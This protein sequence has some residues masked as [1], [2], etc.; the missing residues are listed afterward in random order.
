LSNFAFLR[1]EWP[2]LFEEAAK[3]ESRV[4]ADPTEA[5]F[6]ARRTLE[7]IVRWLF[8]HDSSL[9]W[10]YGQPTLNDLLHDAGF[11][12]LASPKVFQKARLIKDLGNRAVH[13]LRGVAPRDGAQ[14][15]VE[16]FHVCFW[17][18][19]T[20]AR[21]GKP[22]AGMMFATNLVPDADGGLAKTQAQLRQL[23]E[24][25]A[26]R[27]SALAEER[28]R[29]A[30]LDS[31]IAAVRAEIAAAK[32]ANA[33]VADTHDYS[34][35]QTRDYFIDVLLREAGWTLTRGGKDTEYEVTGMPNN[36]GT[37]YA[38]YVLW[39]RNDKPLAV[40]EA[41]RTMRDAKEGQ[42][43]AK[44]YA[45]CLEAMH[46]QRPVIFF[47]NGYEHFIWDDALY[48]PRAVQGFYTRA[49]LELAIQRR[50]TRASLADTSIDK[51][52]VDRY[53]Q[54]RA[55][56]KMGESFERD[57]LRK[58]L[59][60]MATGSGKTRTVIA[61][62]DVLMRA[63][64]V[65]NVLFLADR[66]ALVRQAVNAFKKHLPASSPINLV[67]DKKTDGRVYVST[68]PSM[69][70]QLE[71]QEGRVRFGPGFFD[72]VVIDEAHRSV[73][74]RYR[75]IFDY[76]D[77][78]LIGLTATP[79]A[80]IDRN[81]YSLFDLPNDEPTDVYELA[82][83]VADRNLVPPAPKAIDLQFPRRGIRYADLSEDE[84]SEWEEKDWDEDGFIP[85]EVDPEAVNSWLFNKDTV[86]KM[87]EQLMREGY[88]VAGGDRLGKTIIFAKNQR[89][90][91]FI[92][93]RFNI[94]YPYF[95]GR[96]ARVIHN[97]V[98]YAQSLIDEFS[99]KEKE[100]HIAV[101]VDML[102][103][104]IDVPEVLNLVFAKPV[105]SPTK[106]WQ[107]VGRGTRL[108]PDVFDD[109][110]HKTDFKIFDYCGN[111]EF[112][113]INPTAP[114]RSSSAS[115]GE[116]LFV[117]RLELITTL[118]RKGKLQSDEEQA[119]RHE[120]AAHLHSVVQGMTLDNFLIRPHRLLVERYTDLTAWND[121]AIFNA[122]D[123]VDTLAG[124]PSIVSDN[125][126]DAKQFDLLMFRAQLALLR[127]ET[128]F[129][130]LRGKIIELA[131][132]LQEKSTI[133][134]VQ[135]Q[136]ILILDIQSD[137][138]W[139]G[140]TAPILDIARKK[141]R[142]LVRLIDKSR[143][144]IVITDFEDSVVGEREVMLPG[145][146]SPTAT[147]ETF[148]RKAKAYLRAHEDHIALYRLRRNEALTESDLSELERMLREAGG[149]DDDIDRARSESKSLTAFIR[150]LIGLDREAAKALFSSY[151]TDYGPNSDQINFINMIVDHLTENGTMKAERLY[152]SPFTD[153]S[154]RGA[155]GLF[156]D[157]KVVS[158][159]SIIQELDT[160]AA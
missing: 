19:R 27:D 85:T 115:L 133:P 5:C 30:T 11:R 39:G 154:P 7:H 71:V 138:Y 65:K 17:L 149:T 56:R 153:V 58:A 117:R 148:R 157:D 40:I 43:Q 24:D 26:A 41:K 8:D 3:A 142:G 31:E 64:W 113:S 123:L 4:K 50:K 93:E 69:M 45:D 150:S 57:K 67:T 96:F 32:A 132:A 98:T 145:I 106:F 60:V 54:D 35:Q 23:A 101:S 22:V 131:A 80:E 34:E 134:A 86:D 59:L 33:T 76:F 55:I 37:G 108:C 72:L 9:R 75:A 83:A 49:E 124:L 94:N 155:E 144:R 21:Q 13:E 47:T 14:A 120:T 12:A 29:F 119:L 25:L 1:A 103:T 140:I 48:P 74:Q 158:L 36:E 68:Y 136:M 88:K 126:T 160:K 135:E 89:H 38:D 139:E 42:Q 127:G 146:F 62:I 111:L 70:K 104:G 107:M 152:E 2:E 28:A 92:A 44:L 118:D 95:A 100:P 84:K 82:Q 114:S 90:A 77:S 112:F 151:F 15:V 20:Y 51:A 122:D 121:P 16:L 18:A 116:R 110:D 147:F 156:P 79:K 99:L 125:D 105:R 53:Y 61:A 97:Q 81:T 63:G 6:Y 10:P 78:L 128:R 129:A 46:G 130:G 66:V 159:I 109:G 73:Y 102:D 141:L 137:D 52:I 143:R 91:E 87:L